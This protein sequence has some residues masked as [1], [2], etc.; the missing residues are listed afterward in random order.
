M[1]AANGRRYP[2][3]PNSA[4]IATILACDIVYGW[5]SMVSLSMP[6]NASGGEIVMGEVVLSYTEIAWVS[7][8]IRAFLPKLTNSRPVI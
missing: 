8:S 3:P 7:C 5:V 2:P 6:A 4:R 1:E